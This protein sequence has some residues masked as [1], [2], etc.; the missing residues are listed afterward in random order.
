MHFAWQLTK[1]QSNEDHRIE[2]QSWNTATHGMIQF[3]KCKNQIQL[4]SATILLVESFSLPLLGM[5]AILF[6]SMELRPKSGDRSRPTSYPQEDRGRHESHQESRK[7]ASRK[8]RRMR[9]K[10]VTQHESGSIHPLHIWMSVQRCTQA[11]CMTVCLLRTYIPMENSFFLSYMACDLWRSW[12]STSCPFLIR[13][14]YES[15]SLQAPFTLRP[16]LVDGE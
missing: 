12:Q 6:L 7:K 4:Q 10:Q 11:I 13:S 16:G 2:T 8:W 5:V 3:L 9:S 15:G 14:P 1:S